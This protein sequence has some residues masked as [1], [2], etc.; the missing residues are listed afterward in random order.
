MGARGTLAVRF[1]RSVDRS[2]DCWLWM[3]ALDR[4]GYGAIGADG[5]RKILKAHRVSW[6]LHRGE[7]PAGLFVCHTCDN[8]RCV[9]PSHLF[10]GTNADNAADMA[11]KG[12]APRGSQRRLSKLTEEQ[13]S[14]IKHSS[15]KG[16][17]LARRFG[18]SQ[19]QISV[20]RNGREWKHV[21]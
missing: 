12:R 5:G 18:V 16:I 17:D 13:V 15:E 19:T 11:R 4:G 9:N 8:P 1:W 10:L 20:I 14:A 2:G 6:E 3:K 7:I 21:A